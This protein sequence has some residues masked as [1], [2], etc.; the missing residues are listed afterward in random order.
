[1]TSSSS[2][3]LASMLLLASV[4]VAF[5][6]LGANGQT[7]LGSWQTGRSTFYGDID[8]GNCGFGPIASTA[9]PHRYIAG[10]HMSFPSPPPASH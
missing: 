3:A 6:A 8:D 7:A 2:S 9:F 4:L 1:M 5:A 10:T